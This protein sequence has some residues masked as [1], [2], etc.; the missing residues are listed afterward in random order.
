MNLLDKAI[1]EAIE[2]ECLATREEA[3]EFLAAV[4]LLDNP[5]AI[6]AYTRAIARRWRA[7]IDRR[8]LIE[9]RIATSLLNQLMER[10]RL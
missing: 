7:G 8:V 5:T 10:V 9:M 6:R 2:R 3:L 1:K 4:Y